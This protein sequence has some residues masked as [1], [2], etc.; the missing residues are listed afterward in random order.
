VNLKELYPAFE[1]ASQAMA[2]IYDP[3]F[4]EYSARFDLTIQEMGNIDRHP[5]L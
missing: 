3:V 1:A 5:H 2:L 4:E